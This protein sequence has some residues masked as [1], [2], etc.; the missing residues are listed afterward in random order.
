MANAAFKRARHIARDR[1]GS[2]MIEFAAV[3][4]PFIALILA[5][6]LTSLALFSQQLL[7]TAADKM[8]RRLMTGQEQRAGTSQSAFKT[9]VC[10]ELPEFMPCSR[11]MVNVQKATDYDSAD[12]SAPTITFDSGGDVTNSW[13]YEPGLPGDIVVM[14]VYYRWPALGGPLGF[15]VGNLPNGERLLISTAIFKTEKYQ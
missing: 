14:Q 2:T 6:L 13:K 11:V 9:K 12:T 15:S 1:R 3:A 10:A 5:N 7:D 8:S 4:A